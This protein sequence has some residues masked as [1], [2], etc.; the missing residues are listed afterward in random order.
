MTF[1]IS[2]AEALD[3]A[4]RGETDVVPVRAHLGSLASA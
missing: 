4:F 1:L 2:G 3:L